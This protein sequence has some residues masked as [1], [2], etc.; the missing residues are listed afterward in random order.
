MVLPRARALLVWLLCLYLPS[1]F[2]DDAVANA[3]A[4]IPEHS[5]VLLLS[6][7][8]FASA[9]AVFHP[10]LV[11]FDSPVLKG[12]LIKALQ[13]SEFVDTVGALLA[14]RYPPVFKTVEIVDEDGD[15]VDDATQPGAFE[16]VA[17]ITTTATTTRELRE[18]T[19]ESQS[20]GQIVSPWEIYK[21]QQ[22]ARAENVT[23]ADWILRQ[24]QQSKDVI[25]CFSS[26]WC[27]ACR[28]FVKVLAR[29]ATEITRLSDDA[30]LHAPIFAS[31]NVD[32][33]D[34]SSIS[35]QFTQLPSLFLFPRNVDVDGG[36]SAPPVAFSKRSFTLDEVLSFVH[37]HAELQ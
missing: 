2:A 12:T 4:D 6:D 8:T 31:V 33:V 32:V 25:V 13:T 28:A 36:I 27:Y 34:I 29:V 21:Q 7:A 26:P 35:V 3:V 11:L 1:S 14:Q 30:G 19:V 37:E 20:N 22:Q 23:S 15:G 18:V 9:I 10:M 24:Q 16:S 5:G 17:S